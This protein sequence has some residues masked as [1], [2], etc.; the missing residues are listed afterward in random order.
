MKSDSQTQKVLFLDGYN[1]LYR[2]R[3]GWTQGQNAV[4][5]NFFRSLRAVVGKFNPDTVY[6]VL[7]GRPVQRL[8][9]MPEYK[10]QREYHDRDGFRRQRRYIIKLLKER[11][12]VRTVLHPRYECDD[13]LASLVM[14]THRENE[15]IVVSSDSDFYQ[16]LQTHQNLKLYNPVRKQFIEA[17]KYDYVGWKSLRGDASDNIPGF[18]GIGDK[19]AAGMMNDSVMLEKYLSHPGRREMYDR[20]VRM[21][22]FH[23]LGTDLD[24]IYRSYPD[25]NWPLV[26]KEFND[27][28][29]FS[30]TNNKSWDK[31]VRTFDK[32]NTFYHSS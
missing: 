32:I 13:V 21:I 3:S 4:V 9:E 6:F 5:Y 17:P 20:N 25:P 26:R 16:L 2:A 19:R 29:F 23:D 12:P 18:K 24:E 31:F 7:E 15:C 30:I 22:K 14:S 1:M 8:A 27:L 11:F 28:E 10:S